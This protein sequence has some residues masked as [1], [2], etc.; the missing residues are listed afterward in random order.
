MVSGISG[1]A[2]LMASEMKKTHQ[3]T[4]P[5]KATATKIHGRL[6]IHFGI[7]AVSG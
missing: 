2:F 3:D 1:G 6:E 5:M 4:K 7:M